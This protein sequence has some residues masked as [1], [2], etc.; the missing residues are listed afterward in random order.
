MKRNITSSIFYFRNLGLNGELTDEKIA[1]LQ[2]IVKEER[3]SSK[4]PELF[5]Q[6]GIMDL[7]ETIHFLRNFDCR[8]IADH[9]MAEDSLQDTLD[10]LKVINTRDYRNLKRYYEMAK[11]NADTYTKLSYI[12]KIIY[13]KPFALIRAKT[14]AKQLIKKKDEVELP[15]AS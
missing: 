11:G 1:R 5:Q 7:D 2:N 8:V 9:T 4:W 15:K 12:H 3:D 10:S 13:N 14:D 6:A